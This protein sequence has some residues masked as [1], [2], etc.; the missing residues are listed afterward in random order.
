MRFLHFLLVCKCVAKTTSKGLK[1]E[2]FCKDWD[3]A[4]FKWCYLDG[5]LKAIGCPDATKSKEDDF[6]WTNNT[7]ICGGK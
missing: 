3:S 7:D 1:T 5:G 2:A 6:Y 4:S